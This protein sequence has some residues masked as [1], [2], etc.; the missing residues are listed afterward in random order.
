[1]TVSPNLAFCS[2]VFVATVFMLH[3][4]KIIKINVDEQFQLKLCSEKKL[5]SLIFELQLYW[6]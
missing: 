2:F 4:E 1:M 6:F 3:N 5:V